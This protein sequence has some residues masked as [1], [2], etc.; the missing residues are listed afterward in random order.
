MVEGKERNRQCPC[1]SGLKRKRCPC[2]SRR[3]RTRSVVLDYGNP[4][5][6]DELRVSA[7]GALSLSLGGQPTKPISAY[8][9]T[10][11]ERAGKDPK[12]IH[13]TPL[14]PW[15]P[16]VNPNLALERFDLLVGIDT[17]TA[18]RGVDTISVGCLVKC[19]YHDFGEKIG[20]AWEPR[21]I[22]EFRNAS[23]PAENLT[24]RVFIE[25][26]AANKQFAG[27]RAVGIVVDSDFAMLPS[28]NSRRVPIS[29]DFFLPDRYVLLYASADTGSEFVANRMVARADQVAGA[30]LREIVLSRVG[31]DG[32]LTADGYPFTYYRVWN[33][34]GGVRVATGAPAT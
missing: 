33:P 34:A 22:F 19:E 14:D 24:W 13:R 16:G 17:N 29:G 1:G 6:H 20:V 2:K 21:Q 23:E 7:A 30:L 9:E 18:Q 31:E 25:S 4:T 3:S 15:A 27:M 28:Y 26:I 8:L 5:A 12:V 32:L 11:Y 10:T